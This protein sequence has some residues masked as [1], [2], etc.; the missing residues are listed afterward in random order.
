MFSNQNI[1]FVIF[2]I[3]SL[4]GFRTGLMLILH[5][6]ALWLAHARNSHLS[7]VDSMK[8]AIWDATL[9]I[10]GK[11]IVVGCLLMLTQLLTML[12]GW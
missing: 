6:D 3:I 4:V 11:G 8:P 2:L 9:T 10:T 5:K 7:P 1:T 12:L